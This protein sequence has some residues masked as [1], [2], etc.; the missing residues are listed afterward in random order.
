ME[1]GLWGWIELEYLEENER[2]G[3]H[4]R[5]SGM[6]QGVTFRSEPSVHV[7]TGIVQTTQSLDFLFWGR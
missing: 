3:L 2:R 4:K 6:G 1:S 7:G 5:Q